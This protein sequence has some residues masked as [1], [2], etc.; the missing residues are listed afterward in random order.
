M[1]TARALLA[2][3]VMTGLGGCAG[4]EAP[5]DTVPTPDA[6]PLTMQCGTLSAAFENRGDQPV[7]AVAGER[8]PLTPVRSASGARYE[9]VG[10]SGTTF[11]NKGDRARLTLNGE[12]RPVCLSPGA[13]ARPFEASGN[14]PFW[15]VELDDGTLT[16]ERPG[17][18]SVT[19][20]FRWHSQSASVSRGTV[21]LN[22]GEAEVTVRHEACQDSMSG[23]PHPRQ[24]AIAWQGRTL[25]GCGG[26][27]ARLLRGGTWIVDDLPGRGI[28]D[29]SRMSVTFLEDGRLTGM[30][31]CNRYMGVYRLTGEGLTIRRP[32][33]TLKACAPALMDQ[34]QRFLERLRA[35][36]H[37]RLAKGGLLE[38]VGAD[39][40][41]V[42]L[43]RQSVPSVYTDG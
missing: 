33:S 9:A 16:L 30:A 5:S 19:G 11:W 13:V 4:L 25:S 26:D 34:E 37:F 31:S 18:A 39:G 22:G 15:R 1:G 29:G 36:Q 17:K 32:A 6:G 40:T 8:Y 23:M 41:L 12:P 42:R 27:P 35:V 20:P 24:V 43:H 21:S 2:T 3:L 10:D 7:L 38:L 28:I 14:E